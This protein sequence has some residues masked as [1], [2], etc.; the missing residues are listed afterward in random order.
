MALF[1]G[2]ILI[3]ILGVLIGTLM[4]LVYKI[5][6]SIFLA[7]LTSGIGVVSIFFVFTYLIS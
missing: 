5:T 6:G 3:I 1:L 4:D 2:C 7:F